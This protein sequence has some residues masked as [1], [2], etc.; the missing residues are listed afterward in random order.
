MKDTTRH[1]ATI[2]MI[3][4]ILIGIVALLTMSCAM[5]PTRT[6]DPNSWVQLDPQETKLGS[7][8][9]KANEHTLFAKVISSEQSTATIVLMTHDGKRTT[10]NATFDMDNDGT[11]D[12]STITYGTYND[13]VAPNL[14]PFTALSYPRNIKQHQLSIAQQDYDMIMKL[15]KT[16]K[17][18]S[19]LEMN[20]IVKALSP[21]SIP[22]FHE[23][24]V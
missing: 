11:I 14:T 6:I 10:M 9:A 20:A 5:I 12:K 23:R 13:K 7:G 2:A 8:C 15:W 1:V 17:H 4:I 18:I 24:K 21:S 16:G 19:L 3:G 22:S